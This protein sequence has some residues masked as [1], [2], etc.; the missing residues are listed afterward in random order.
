[1]I[2]TPNIIS[3]NRKGGD[4]IVSK[5]ELRFRFHNP[6]TV[7]DTADALLK[8]FVEVNKGK[9]DEAIR[10]AAESKPELCAYLP[11]DKTSMSA[12]AV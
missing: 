3:L 7:E 10:K 4:F 8:L 2:C 11:A 6:N 1:M 5:Q 9:V 12:A